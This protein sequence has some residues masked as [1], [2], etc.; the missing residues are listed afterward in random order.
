MMTKGKGPGCMK[1]N[2]LCK[3]CI[4]LLATVLL[5]GIASAAVPSIFGY[6]GLVAI[7]TSDC[8]DRGEYA[9]SAFAVDVDSDT[10]ANAYGGNVGIAPMTEVGFSRI[11]P[12][13][14]TGETWVNAKHQF[15][16]ETE[17][18][19]AIAVGLIDITGETESTAYFVL[20]K[21]ITRTSGDNEYGDVIAPQIHIGAGGGILEGFFGGLSA[22]LGDRF[23]L[24]AE[25]DSSNIN[26]GA[27][28][29]ITRELRVHG[30]LLDGDDLALGAS[31]TK[32]F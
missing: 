1:Q 32:A 25:Y 23:F 15:M 13:D 20:T 22:S 29:T 9:A 14:S 24:M 5:S 8:L 17:T 16:V 6:S 28:L 11:K 12:D 2:L 3:L 27:R 31:F 18:H 21:S 4:S 10:D 7:P 19:P 30:A 26:F